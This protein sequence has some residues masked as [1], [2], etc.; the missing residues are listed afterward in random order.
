MD[1]TTAMETVKSDMISKGF[2]MGDPTPVFADI[3]EEQITKSSPWLTNRVDNDETVG[4]VVT[5]G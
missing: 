1:L 3:P 2:D 5:T 4:S